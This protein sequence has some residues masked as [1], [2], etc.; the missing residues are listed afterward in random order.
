[1]TRIAIDID[2]TLYS[3]S[4]VVKDALFRIGIE[5]DQKDV[6]SAAYSGMGQWR[7][8][9]DVIGIESWLE[10]IGIVHHP[11]VIEAQIPYS[12]AADTVRALWKNG[13]SITYVSN[14]QKSSEKATH[15][16]LKRNGFPLHEDSKSIELICSMENK[17]E[18]VRHCQYIIDDRPK[19]LVE[20]VYDADWSHDFPDDQRRGFG[21]LT[22]YNN[23]LTDISNIY[24]APSWAGMNYYLVEKGLLEEPAHK[25]LDYLER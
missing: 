17:L 1:M 8:P 13:H 7:T 2:D 15:N 11:D 22:P 3:F 4:D 19:Y 12:G 18:L 16:W 9:V 20:F 10:A 14:R 23:N 6:F 5:K 21:L 25:P 24:L